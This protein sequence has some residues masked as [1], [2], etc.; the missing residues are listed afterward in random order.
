MTSS[1]LGSDG[2]LR[3]PLYHGT[4]LHRWHSI[5]Q[6]GLGARDIL[7]EIDA[8]EVWQHL[9]ALLRDIASPE[10]ERK[11][12]EKQHRFDATLRDRGR[13][14]T[15]ASWNFRYGSVYLSGSKHKAATYAGRGFGS[16][17][18]RDAAELFDH[19][20]KYD[21]AQADELL[22]SFPAFAADLQADHSPVLIKIDRVHIDEVKTEQGHSAR[23]AI[24]LYEQ[25]LSF[26][27]VALAPSLQAFNFEA[28]VVFNPE[29][30]RPFLVEGRMS[31]LGYLSDD[32][33]TLLALN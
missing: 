11:L 14:S 29:R 22:R 26:L 18:V 33:F 10:L 31:P 3:F 32:E 7:K 19:F 23:D 2:Y 17:L 4:S 13:A 5:A 6:E 24:S 20:R 15:N 1:L 25:R 27:P 12:K 8:W 30:L 9:V 21:P 28:A 16:E